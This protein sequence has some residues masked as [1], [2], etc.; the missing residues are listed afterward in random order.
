[1]RVIKSVRVRRGD[2]NDSVLDIKVTIYDDGNNGFLMDGVNNNRIILKSSYKKDGIY[3]NFSIDDFINNFIN[4]LSKSENILYFIVQNPW[5]DN[6]PGTRS[7]GF[8]PYY[9]NNGASIYVYWSIGTTSVGG[10]MYSDQNGNEINVDTEISKTVK[11]IG[12]GL[13]FE[14]SDDGSIKYSK[15]IKKNRIYSSTIKD[16][17]I[18]NETISKWNSLIPGYNLEICSPSNEK[19]SLIEFKDPLKPISDKVESTISTNENTTDKPKLIASVLNDKIKV[20]YD[21]AIRILLGDSLKTNTNTDDYVFDDENS[22]LDPE[23]TESS[24]EGSEESSWVPIPN[25]IDD[26][27]DVDKVPSNDEVSLESSLPT[28]NTQKSFIKSAILATLA[29]GGD[30]G[31]CARFSFNHAYNYIRLLQGKNTERGD[32]YA[33]GGNAKD[34]GYHRNLEN[35]G[36][37]KVDKGTIDKSTLSSL[38]NSSQWE[39]GDVVVYWCVDS[40]SGSKNSHIKYG[41]TQIFTNGYHNDSSYR[42]SCDNINNY[43]GAFIYSNRVG[44]NY[45]FLIFKAPKT[46]RINDSV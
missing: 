16:K 17:D 10:K 18:V 41:H 25:N 31:R 7:Y 20:K 46:K 32:K 33:A 38:L 24:F 26:Y 23:Y 8:D 29:N 44:N 45:R 15:D 1:M 4:T 28:T 42:W 13:I 43:R 22:M 34:S 39:V 6:L 3:K 11:I 2:I 14:I 37:K 19:C 35:I 21:F 5:S 36:Y 40:Y 30:S 27:P 12:N 9:T